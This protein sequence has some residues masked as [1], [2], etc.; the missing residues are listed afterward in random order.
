MQTWWLW[1]TQDKTWRKTLKESSPAKC[2]LMYL[3]LAFFYVR[4]FKKQSG[5]KGLHSPAPHM[6][7]NMDHNPWPSYW[8]CK[9]TD[10]MIRLS[11]TISFTSSTKVV[12]LTCPEFLGLQETNPSVETSMRKRCLR[13]KHFPGESVRAL[14]VIIPIFIHDRLDNHKKLYIRRLYLWL[15]IMGLEI[16]AS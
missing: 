9:W 8:R 13:G 7:H 16:K 1:M 4:F 2:C 5:S 6:L 10:A 3:D 11:L 15:R 12:D 14:S